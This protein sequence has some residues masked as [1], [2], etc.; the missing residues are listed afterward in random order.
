M[1][2]SRR[3]RWSGSCDLRYCDLLIKS[4][5]H[6]ISQCHLDT[7]WQCEIF[8]F[9]FFANVITTITVL[10]SHFHHWTMREIKENLNFTWKQFKCELLFGNFIYYKI[11]VGDVD[12]SVSIKL[13][14]LRAL[15]EFTLR[16]GV[17]NTCATIRLFLSSDT[18]SQQQLLPRDS[19]LWNQMAEVKSVTSKNVFFRL[20]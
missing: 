13:Q 16:H 3:R 7:K 1:M 15:Y 14:S 17:V 2:S 20:A 10:I 18:I 8:V 9:F 4:L 19:A 6:S 5:L 11:C 12:T